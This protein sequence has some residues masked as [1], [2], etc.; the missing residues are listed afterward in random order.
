MNRTPYKY[1]MCNK[2]GIIEQRNCRAKIHFVWTV[3]HTKVHLMRLQ[4]PSLFCYAKIYYFL[5]EF[6]FRN[7]QITK[8]GTEN[9]MP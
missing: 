6:K 1:W 9:G 2:V 4:F 7:E 3:T 5:G 8:F